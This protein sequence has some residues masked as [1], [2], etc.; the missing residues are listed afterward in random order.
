M[1]VFMGEFWSCLQRHV[2]NIK[3]GFS[4]ETNDKDWYCRFLSTLF[5]KVDA[6]KITTSAIRKNIFL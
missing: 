5:P 6:I 4:F 2:P 3:N 1:Y